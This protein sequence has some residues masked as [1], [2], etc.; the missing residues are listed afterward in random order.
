MK[1]AAF[2]DVQG[3]LQAF[4]Q[5]VALIE[6]WQ[7]DLVVNAGDL[8]NRG[9]D[10]GACLELFEHYRRRHGWLPVLGNHEVWTIRW[11][12]EGA[13]S[14][15]EQVM[16]AF[17][18][19]TWRQV[20]PLAATLDTWPDHLCFDAPGERPQQGAGHWVHVAHGTL[21]GHR[22][23]VSARATDDS[24]RGKLPEDLALYITGHTHKVH[25]RR[26]FGMEL[27]NVGSV[28]SPFDGDVRGS[29]GFFEFRQGRWHTEIRRFDYDRALSERRYED[30]GFLDQ[31]GP[32]VRIILR[33]WQ[34]ARPILASWRRQ[35]EAGVLS[36][37]IDLEWS[38][39]QFL[40]AQH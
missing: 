34:Q 35:Y 40:Q 3:N 7:P 11:G 13:R 28:G 12:R 8:L 20:E 17:T 9:P 32:L 5:A 31:G 25:Q 29:L 30:S 23:G 39:E 38:V 6:A 10:S 16:Y 33:E 36:G 1:L 24:L 18:D 15:L 27:V 21:A 22:D 2:S 37:E 26:I 19:W 4:E 14:P